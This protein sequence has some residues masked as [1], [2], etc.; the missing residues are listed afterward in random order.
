MAYARNSAD[1]MNFPITFNPGIFLECLA[2]M[3]PKGTE[4]LLALTDIFFPETYFDVP[5]DGR[6]KITSQERAVSSA[7]K[8][9]ISNWT[10]KKTKEMVDSLVVWRELVLH[11]ML[12]LQWELYASNTFH[13]E[14]ITCERRQ[15]YLGELALHLKTH[16][17]SGD[18]SWGWTW[19][20]IWTFGRNP[21]FNSPSIKFPFETTLKHQNIKGELFPKFSSEYCHNNV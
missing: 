3:G 20:T 9:D 1:G 11:R 15:A 10:T 18:P 12:V 14:N 19:S 17:S 16:C 6:G 4:L 13:T 2:R 21:F 5:Q 8:E 7:S